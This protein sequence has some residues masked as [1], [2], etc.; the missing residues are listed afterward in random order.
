[1]ENEPISKEPKDN[2]IL[3]SEIRRLYHKAVS[4]EELIQGM[5]ILKE[6]PEDISDPKIIIKLGNVDKSHKF[7]FMEDEDGRKYFIALPIEKKE[8]HSEIANFTRRLYKKDIHVIG[9]GYIHTEGDKLIIDGTSESY[10]EAPKNIIKE[11]LQTKIPNMEIE[12]N[13]LV[14]MD[15]K[16]KENKYKNMLKSL[17]TTVQQELYA[18]VLDHRAI[19]LRC[20]YTSKPKNIEGNNDLAYMIYSSENGSSFG[21]D[22]LYIAYKNKGGEIKS[23]DIVRT[24]WYM[25][26]DEI[27]IEDNCIKIKYTTSDK[28]YTVTVPLDD[29]KNFDMIS[30]LEEAENQLVEMYKS[31][32]VLLKNTNVIHGLK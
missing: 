13:F 28:E 24:R 27:K 18:D 32:Q 21:F 12:S 5:R 3:S 26:I 11:I 2:E 29:I 7:V 20:D 8:M 9:G 6:I 23:K 14:D 17:K 16:N 30:N 4:Q 31:N 19:K 1:M 25:H 15:M 22:T 10:G